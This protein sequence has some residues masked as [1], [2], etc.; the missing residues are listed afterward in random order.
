M[1]SIQYLDLRDFI[2]QLERDGKLKR[3]FGEVDPYLEM[4]AV[5]DRTLRQ[6]GPALLF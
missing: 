2:A 6:A 5:C 4:S 1:G 3:V